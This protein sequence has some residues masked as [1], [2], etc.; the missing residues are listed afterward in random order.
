MSPGLTLA[1][2][3]SKG[4]PR[5]RVGLV[6]HV[7]P[8]NALIEDDVLG[9]VKRRVRL[10]DDEDCPMACRLPVDSKGGGADHTSF[11]GQLSAES[12]EVVFGRFVLDVRPA[13]V[14]PRANFAG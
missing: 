14:Q 6:C 10:G 2:R 8:Q 12:D 11:V 4:P 13:K 5:S 7:N 1:R 3:T 9:L